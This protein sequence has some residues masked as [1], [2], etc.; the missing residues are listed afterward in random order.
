MKRNDKCVMKMVNN[1]L[2]KAGE[3]SNEIVTN[4][5]KIYF[6]IKTIN[7]MNNSVKDLN[8]ESNQ[9][10]LEEEEIGKENEFE[11]QFANI[12]NMIKICFNRFDKVNQDSI[13]IKDELRPFLKS[14][15]NL[16]NEKEIEFL[17]HLVPNAHELNGK[18]TLAQLC[19]ICG[20]LINFRQKKQS[21]IVKFAFDHYYEQNPQ[22]YRDNILKWV[23][24][25][26]FFTFYKDY[27]N[28]KHLKY[29]RDESSYLG[30]KFTLD[31]FI[32]FI[33]TPNQY[34]SY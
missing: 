28:Q 11:L 22:M 23:N 9:L 5:K 12:G 15:G 13:L 19:S 17:L 10:I 4:F 31:E 1:Q 25:E 6:D 14:C 8:N 34:Y 33:T 16:L 29:I 20:A 32:M 30:D 18:L 21:D 3:L 24:I 27:F 2:K 26:E 7:Y